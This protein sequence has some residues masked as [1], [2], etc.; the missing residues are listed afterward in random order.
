MELALQWQDLGPL[1]MR[2]SKEK[3][4]SAVRGLRS[5]VIVVPSLCLSAYEWTVLES[6]VFPADG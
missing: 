6:E 1:G 5:S 2:R 3:C 4:G